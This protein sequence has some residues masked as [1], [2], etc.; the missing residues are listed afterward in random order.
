MNPA[1]GPYAFL[2][3]HLEFMIWGDLQILA[4]ARTVPEE[5]YHKDRG[6]SAGSLHALLLH[7]MGAQW[8]WLNR[9]QGRAFSFAEVTAFPTRDALAARWPEV[10]DA[11]RTY[12]AAQT[13]ESL[14]VPV[15]FKNF[16]GMEFTQ[17]MGH[18]FLHVTDHGTYHR[19]QQNT[20]IKLCGGKPVDI[21]FYKW[22]VEHARG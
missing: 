10:H 20:F 13:A 21:F 19:G 8:I 11:L 6:I 5:E 3:D 12:L 16:R 9:F 7:A 2:P 4:A 15:T 14:N 1:L 18:A 17:P 22:M